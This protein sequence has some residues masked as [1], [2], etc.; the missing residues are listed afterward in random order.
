[1]EEIRCE[2]RIEEA[3]GKPRLRGVLMPYGER[4]KDRAEVFDVGSLSW[5]ESGIIV[6]RMHRRASP[7]C[8]RSRLL[9][10]TRSA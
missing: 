1:M 9:R 6:N 5:P 4:A 8:G 3:E 10:A 7:S 2:I